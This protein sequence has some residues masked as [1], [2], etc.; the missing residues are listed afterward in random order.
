M[1]GGRRYSLHPQMFVTFDFLTN[2]DHC[3]IKEIYMKRLNII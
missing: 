2:F 3:H 1:N